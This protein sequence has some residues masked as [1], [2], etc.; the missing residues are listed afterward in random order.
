MTALDAVQ[1]STTA[2]TE[3]DPPP[4]SNP[5]VAIPTYQLNDA[6]NEDQFGGVFGYFKDEWKTTKGD[7]TKALK[8]RLALN[9]I[10]N[11][12]SIEH[13]GGDLPS[14]CEPFT[15]NLNDYSDWKTSPLGS[16]D[17]D[18]SLTKNEVAGGQG[19][20][21]LVSGASGGS[22][23]KFTLN[24]NRWG[25]RGKGYYLGFK[26]DMK[27]NGAYWLFSMKNFWCLLP[28]GCDDKIY[29]DVD[30]MF[31]RINSCMVSNAGK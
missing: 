6:T 5:T 15:C 18:Y 21:R 20:G 29:K 9:N 12:F 28:Q 31:G 17:T 2:A 11:I 24:Y 27:K 1:I 14:S 4:P 30:F 23:G 10:D 25:I 3:G 19:F 16:V 13:L 8:D 22:N 7:A 26:L